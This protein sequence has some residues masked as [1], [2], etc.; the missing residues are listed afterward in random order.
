[1]KVTT[2]IKKIDLVLFSL[3]ILPKSRST[4]TDLLVIII[5]F[6]ALS[7]WATGFSNTSRDWLAILIVSFSG[8]TGWMLLCTVISMV[9]TLLTPPKNNEDAGVHE[10]EI[11]AEGIHKKTIVSE[12]LR[13]WEGIEKIRITGL[14]VLFE[15]PDFRFY[16]IP[17]RSFESP[18]HFNQFVECSKKY[19]EEAHKVKLI[20]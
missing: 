3:A 4:Y 9:F 2:E 11:T 12:S 8:G 10:Y 17:K 15:V 20:S 18:E 13:K 5:L 6:F 14:Y 7:C 19:W 16:V 1:M